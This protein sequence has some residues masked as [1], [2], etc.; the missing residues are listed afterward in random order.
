QAAIESIFDALRTARSTLLVQ[1]TGCHAPGTPIL[2]FDG[3]VK[4]VEDVRV[5]DR[6]MGPDSRPRHVLA[7]AHG[8]GRMY[9]IVPVKGEPFVVNEDHILTL[10]RTS[11]KNGRPDR[12]GEVIDVSVHEWLSWPKYRKH[13]HKLLRTGV[14]FP[15]QD[16]PVIDPYFLGVLLGDGGLKRGISV[17]TPEPEIVRELEDQARLRR[18]RLR[19]EPA[20][21]A[22]TYHFVSE[23]GAVGRYGSNLH[24]ELV[25]LGLR[26][27]GSGDKFVPIEYRSARREDRLALLAGLMDTDGHLTCGGYD[28]ISQSPRL[29]ADLAFVARSVGLA[30]YVSPCTKTCTQTDSTGTYYRVSI[31]GDASCIPC[32]VARKKAPPRRQKKDVLRT[33]FHAEFLGEG[34][35]YGFTLDADGRFLLGDFT[36]THNTGKTVTFAH[37]INRMPMGRTLVLAHREEL[38]F[39]A[40]DKIE[41]VTGAKPDIEMAEMR[42]D[43]AMF[44]KARVVVSSIQTQCAG[45]NGDSR[46]KRFDPREFALLVVDEAHHATAPTYRRVLEHYGQNPDLKILGVTATPDRHD[47]EALGQVFDSVAFDYELL[48]AIHDGW[49]VP[50]RQRSVVVDGLDYSSIRTTAGDLNGADL[51]RVMEYEETLHAVAA[52]TLDLAAGRKTLVFAA[53]VAHAERLCEIF[54]RHRTEAAR[55]VTGTTPKDE[56]RGMLA[57]YAAGKFQILVNVG[58]ATEGFDEPGIACVVMARPTKSRALY[59]QMA[60]R[61]TRPLPGLVDAHPEA[62][63]RRAAIAASVKPACEIIDFVGNSGRHRLITTADILGGNYSDEVVARARAKAEEADGAAVDMAEALADAEKELAEERERARRAAIRAK[64]RY[65]CQV[66]DPFDVFHI[67][68]WRERGWD[69]GREPSEKMLALLERNGIDTKGLSFTQ[70]KQLVGEIIRRYEER[71]CSFKQ[72]RLLA[73]YGYPTDVPF[74]EASRLIDALAKNG[75]KRPA[76]SPAEPVEV[77]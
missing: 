24:Q 69:K 66:V 48:D 64:A 47:E 13:L 57:D 39:Q 52:P 60:G 18:M 62:D 38:I 43:H 65:S 25:L 56:R 23:M 2:M 7:L 33:G 19:A 31:S 50:I 49:L 8:R 3:S 55:F 1:P 70:A 35:Y 10:V 54:N 22:E 27:R 72:A 67:E 34:E 46:M 77:Y 6:L 75:W 41:A 29:A 63:A 21:K 32:R 71:K 16:P 26:G 14:N 20:G 51:A 76:D 59:A 17:T 44:G 11:E 30:A 28:Y 53:S 42:A 15:A 45:R 58:V 9:R 37:V 36:V 61:G 68:P 73:R 12:G 74:A 4:P 5:G 40:A